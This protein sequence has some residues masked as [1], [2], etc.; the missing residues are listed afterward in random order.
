MQTLSCQISETLMRALEA[1]SMRTGEP[2]SHIVMSVLADALEVEHSTLFQISTS[3]ALVKGVYNG[4]VTVGDLKQ[5]GD[6]GLGTFDGLDGEML[7]FDGHFYQVRGSGEVLEPGNDALVPFAVVTAFRPEHESSIEKVRNF[8][9]LIALL[10]TLRRS[11][12]LFSAVRI[13]GRFARVNTRA[14]CRASPG[15]SLVKAASHQAE[16][17]FADVEGTIVG[18]WTPSFARTISIAG[19]HLHFLTSD[20]A[21]GGHLLDCEAATLRVAMQDL[22]DLRLAMPES[23]AFLQADLGQDPT[24]DLDIAE[25]GA[26]RTH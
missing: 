13:D 16:F 11:D 15:T 25:R 5:H 22:S 6:F 12:N 1:R 7:A 14:V 4:V 20:R 18:F 10:D 24:K 9:E 8:H 2:P 17:T 23:A 3:T 26:S 21:G 19:W